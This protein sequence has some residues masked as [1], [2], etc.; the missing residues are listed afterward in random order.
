MRL[1]CSGWQA[2]NAKREEAVVKD[3]YLKYRCFSFSMIRKLTGL[4][5]FLKGLQG[6]YDACRAGGVGIMM[7]SGVVS[8]RTHCNTLAK[9]GKTE[10]LAK[11]IGEKEF[12][13]QYVDYVKE[14]HHEW[15]FFMTIDLARISSEI[16]KRYIA[17][18]KM[19]APLGVKPLPVLHG[20]DNVSK[21]IGMYADRGCT[22]VALATAKVLRNR[23]TQFRHYL[24]ACF[25]AGERYGVKFHGLAFTSIWMM[26][27]FP[28]FSADSSSWSRVA[29]FGGIMIYDEIKQR[30]HTYHISER[31]SDAKG[32]GSDLQLNSRMMDHVREYVTHTGYDFDVMRKGDGEEAFIERH[33][34][35]ARTMYL[36]AEAATKKHGKE[37]GHF[38]PLIK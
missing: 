12:I 34:W 32:K 36:L 27:E 29:G 10:A 23:Q 2:T 13:Q 28:M 26:L 30:M 7:D 14:R 31:V 22:F 37:Q 1:Y 20:D 3:N 21:Y 11:V 9:Q 35:N 19:V 4:P 24:E 38:N 33:K 16:F 5:Y 17:I 6:A 15:D 8:W 18:E 25:E